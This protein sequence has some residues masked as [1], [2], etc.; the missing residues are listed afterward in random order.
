MLSDPSENKPPYGHE[1]NE[2]V[3]MR[4]RQCEIT[5]NDHPPNAYGKN[6]STMSNKPSS[7]IRLNDN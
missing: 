3:P 5:S 7:G 1:D 4:K 2:K 6:L